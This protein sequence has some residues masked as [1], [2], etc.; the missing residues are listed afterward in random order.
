MNGTSYYVEHPELAL[1]VVALDYNEYMEGWDNTHNIHKYRQ[2][3][4]CQYTPCQEKC[5]KLLKQRANTSNH[6][7]MERKA[8]TDAKI[9]VVFSHYPT[10]YLW[11]NPK[12]LASLSDSKKHHVAYFS[13]HRHSVDT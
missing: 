12:L 4:D 7:H 5:E 1:E 3:H 2:P 9:L 8:A 13:G 10:D 6:L 11:M